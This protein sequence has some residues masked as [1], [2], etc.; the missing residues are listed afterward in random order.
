MSSKNKNQVVSNAVANSFKSVLFLVIAIC[1]SVIF[2]ATLVSVFTAANVINV[3]AV[4][5][6]GVSTLCA[7]LLYATKFTNK[8]LK[9]LRLY[10]AYS[11]VL[12]TIS[13]V[14]VCIIGVV[15][16]G[17]CVAL[18]LASDMINE[19][20]VPVLEE[21]IKP[22]LE[23]I[24]KNADLAEEE[25]G[26]FEEAFNEMPD[27]IKEMY[28]IESAEEFK[29]LISDVKGIAEKALE[30]WDDIIKFLQTGFLTLTII[31][32]VVFVLLIVALSFVS[33]SLKKT[34]KYLK[35]LSKDNYTD[36]T[37]PY[38]TSFIG[39]AF[40]AIGGLVCFAFDAMTALAF[41]A[42]AAVVI[43]FAIFLK[44]M[45]AAVAAEREEMAAAA[46]EAAV[47]EA[48]AAA[49][50]APAEEAQAEVAEEAPVE[51]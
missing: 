31:V 8:R 3:L 11:K 29:N 2:V 20:L 38:I 48:V 34:A 15:L 17:G 36:K 43:L 7:W 14:L 1:F 51:E 33:K 25:I 19:E 50:D 23:E 47:A 41:I 30:I 49:T 16:I 32:A 35:A 10:V 18:T 42:L 40:I 27:E 5:F 26:D 13:I 45:S 12:T 21:D 24:V 37:A 39:G 28:G 22:M 4:I 46:V 9:N 6:A 44:N